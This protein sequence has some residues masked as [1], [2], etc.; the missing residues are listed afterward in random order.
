M[1][2]VIYRGNYSEKY[3]FKT[4]YI[5]PAKASGL[6]AVPGDLSVALTWKKATN[7]TH[8]Y[9]QVRDDATGKISAAGRTRNL[10]YTV[11]GL[12]NKKEYSFRVLS[13]RLVNKHTTYAKATGWV[14]AVPVLQAPSAPTSLD[15]KYTD[16]GNVLTWSNV[17]KA[18]GYVVYS[19]DYDAKK[20]KKVATV[21]DNTW[22][23]KGNGESGKFKY[24]V[25]AFRKEDGKTLYSPAI[26]KLVY[27]NQEILAA[28][29]IHPILYSGKM[30]QTTTL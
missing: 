14:K 23:D 7:A 25:K 22:T 2:G 11:E 3:L 19:Y 5:T 10:K 15:V 27:G 12:E 16:D 20:N 13:Y 1:D 24:S 29:E 9:I 8:Y 6:K 21:T 4:D 26:S 17:K 30:N 28:S 18:N